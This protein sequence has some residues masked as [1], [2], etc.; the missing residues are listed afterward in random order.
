MRAQRG[1]RGVSMVKVSRRARVCAVVASA[2]ALMVAPA[3]YA[4]RPA[5]VGDGVPTGQLGVQMFNYGSY[6]NNGGNTGDANPITGVS[7]ECATST[8]AECRLQ[9]LEGLFAFLKRK[10][11]TNIELFAHAGFPAQN[12]IPGLQAYRALLDKY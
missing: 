11:L 1:L 5:K 4:Q 12:D 7:A 3:A 6:L 2:A 8:T 9:R 10:G